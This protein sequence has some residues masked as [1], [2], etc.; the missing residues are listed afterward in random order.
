[1]AVNEKKNELYTL[2]FSQSFTLASFE[3][4]FTLLFEVL[5]R[6]AAFSSSMRPIMEVRFDASSFGS[7]PA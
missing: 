7:L 4:V 3:P 1:M 6:L 2:H 5:T